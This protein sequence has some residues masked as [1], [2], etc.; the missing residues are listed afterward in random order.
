VF[1]KRRQRVLDAMDPG[2]VAIFL[3]SRLQTRSRDTEYPFRQDSDFWYL[4]GFDHPNAIAV[5]RRD[6]GPTYTLFVEPRDREREIWT[7]YR[8]GTEGALRDYGADEA[9]TND[10]FPKRLPDLVRGAR[11]LYHV[12]GRDASVDGA[13]SQTLDMLRLR[14]RQNEEPADR[15]VDPRSIVHAMRLHKEPAEL[16]IMRR[17]AEISREAHA[18]AARLAWPGNFEY[19]LDAALE[20]QFR[21]R[22][23]RGAAYTSIVGGGANATVLHYV[24]NDQKLRANE[25]VLIDAGCELEGY[26]SDVTRT[27]PIGG[28]MSGPPR[29]I[30]EVVLAAQRAALECCR[31]G[32]TLP[33]VHDTAVRVI[34]EGLVALSILEGEVDE[35][36]ANEAHR[37]YYMHSTSHWLG[38]DVHDVGSYK[39]DGQPRPLEKGMVFTVEPG[40]YI[41]ADADVSDIRY[42]GI[43]VRI[44]DDVVITDDGHENLTADIPVEP[45]ALEALVREGTATAEAH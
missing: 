40:L 24:S 32:A 27:Y 26:A 35:L 13:I 1:A 4:T 15:I 11:V 29:A 30:Y 22:G 39:Q 19:E 38:L 2:G 17:A 18:A 36:V 6:G 16:D 37:P 9:F 28:R 25:L 7:G 3:G 45:G 20:Y 10:E 41:A 43:G 31:P 8:P 21:R 14:S 12:L 5:L 44:E 33:E 42:R 23:A 34:V